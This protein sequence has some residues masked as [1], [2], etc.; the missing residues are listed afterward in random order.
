[1]TQADM[2][3]QSR[4]ARACGIAPRNFAA[5]GVEPAARDG[6][7]KL[8]RFSDVL[9]NRLAEQ[10]A[11]YQAQIDRLEARV[12]ELETD[13]ESGKTLAEVMLAQNIERTRLLAEQAEAQAM[14]NAM[15]RHETAPF[16]LIT[17]V[18]A[19]VAAEIASV[20]D[21]LPGQLIRI[22]SLKNT[23]L[24]KVRSITAAASDRIADLGND[25][26][27]AQQFDNYLK[28]RQQ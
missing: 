3:N 20:M 23:D 11:R 6:R 28:E 24:D 18:L 4:M 14:K 8:Y 9:D 22:T 1:M 26:F 15:A 2:L 17:Y 5:W 13:D 21:G 19:Q 7:Q 25:A 10:A 16:E 12:V 27:V